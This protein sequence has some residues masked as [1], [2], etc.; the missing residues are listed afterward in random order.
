MN[1]AGYLRLMTAE[2][3]AMNMSN[4]VPAELRGK[5]SLPSAA[6]GGLGRRL[7]S[8]PPVKAALLGLYNRIFRWYH[9]R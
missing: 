4:T 8:L 6:P 1:N 5:E 9:A 2:P 7:L 3:Y